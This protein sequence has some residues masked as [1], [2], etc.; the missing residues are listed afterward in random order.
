MSQ[1][2]EVL[3]LRLEA[4][5][6]AWGERARWTVR[7]TRTE[8]T[9]SGVIGLIAAASGWGLDEGGEECVSRLASRI[10][11][12]VRADLP[13][14]VI[15]DYHTVV[16]GALS[17]E[18]KVKINQSTKLP[19]TVVSA[20]RTKLSG[21][22]PIQNWALFTIVPAGASSSTLTVRVAKATKGGRAVPSSPSVVL[23]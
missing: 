4:P 15:R 16:G 22:S 9:K 18:R 20:S 11:M 19:E 23:R 21:S 6:Q 7:D 8:P 1:P 13:G 10:H 3:M 14:E 5:L 2:V 12:A 17:A